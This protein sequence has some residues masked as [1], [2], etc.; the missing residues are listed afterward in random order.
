MQT[1]IHSYDEFLKI[2]GEEEKE[3]LHRFTEGKYTIPE[4]RSMTMFDFN[5]KVLLKLD[6]DP[7]YR[8]WK[9]YYELVSRVKRETQRAKEELSSR[10]DRF[11][12][13]PGGK[14]RCTHC[15]IPVDTPDY[16]TYLDF[17]AWAMCRA[18]AG[19]AEI[20]TPFI[21][22]HYPGCVET[23]SWESYLW[24]DLPTFQRDHPPKK[25]WHYEY[26]DTHI[27]DVKDDQSEWWVL[28]HI[29]HPKVMK[30]VIEGL[31]EW[32]PPH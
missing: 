3:H 32:H 30:D 12:N 28:W 8:R 20:L 14:I 10:Q 29:K 15:G 24:T 19:A 23:D 5:V 4:M 17:G 26:R 25:G 11:I 13:E 31:P 2:I 6:R 21:V 9:P 7:D 27:M 16:N 22:H 1:Y 18:C